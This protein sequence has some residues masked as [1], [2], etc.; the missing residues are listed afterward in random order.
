MPRILVV[1]RLAEVFHVNLRAVCSGNGIGVIPVDACCHPV[2]VIVEAAPELGVLASGP[3][4]EGGPAEVDEEQALPA[5]G[6]L[7]AGGG[8][9]GHHSGREQGVGGVAGGANRCSPVL[10]RVQTQAE[11]SIFLRSPQSARGEHRAGRPLMSWL[12]SAGLI[13]QFGTALRLTPN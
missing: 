9:G 12:H 13:T 2:G 11:A 8:R 7:A 1:T 3:R 6:P 5:A 4:C 10:M